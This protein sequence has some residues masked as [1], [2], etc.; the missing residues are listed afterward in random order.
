MSLTSFIILPFTFTFYIPLH[1]TK[2]FTSQL[3]NNLYLLNNPPKTF[4]H[5]KLI[6][7]RGQKA[8]IIYTSGSHHR[9]AKHASFRRQSFYHRTS[10]R[11]LASVDGFELLAR[12]RHDIIFLR[13]ARAGRT[14]STYTVHTHTYTSLFTLFRSLCV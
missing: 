8:H 2:I 5:Q 7:P 12:S 11:R 9:G 10:T 1:K 3:A 13:K 14:P 4:N 6:N